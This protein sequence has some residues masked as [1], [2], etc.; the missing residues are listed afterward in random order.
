MVLQVIPLKKGTLQEALFI[1]SQ[2][3]YDVN[4]RYLLNIVDL[5]I[6]NMD[7]LIQFKR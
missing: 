3:L 4:C 7:I 1:S 5:Q 2:G 6:D